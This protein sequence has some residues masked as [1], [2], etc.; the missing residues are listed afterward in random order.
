MSECYEYVPHRLLRRRVRDIASGVEGV[1]M[2]V[3]NENVSDTGIERWM[4]LAYIRG[5]SGREFTTAVTNVEPAP[6]QPQ[7]AAGRRET[8][9]A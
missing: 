2:A 5:A 4:E 3:I 8:R 6:D 1:L 7:T 9:S